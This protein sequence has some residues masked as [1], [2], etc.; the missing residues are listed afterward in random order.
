MKK[1]K[2][3]CHFEKKHFQNVKSKKKPIFSRR[4]ERKL[5]DKER[6]DLK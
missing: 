5:F 6:K 4:E 1:K 3:L 2:P